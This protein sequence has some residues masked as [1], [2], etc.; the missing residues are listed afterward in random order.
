MGLIIYYACNTL[1]VWFTN[2]TSKFLSDFVNEHTNSQQLL[3]GPVLVAQY[4]E[5]AQPFSCKSPPSPSHVCES[6]S[7]NLQ[8]TLHSLGYYYNF[9]IYCM[10]ITLVRPTPQRGIGG[11]SGFILGCRAV[12][13]KKSLQKKI[14]GTSGSFGLW[15]FRSTANCRELVATQ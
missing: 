7:W 2:L 1:E 3:S 6:F 9:F 5:Q 4:G 11:Y 14:A 13:A 8:Q 10:C 12:E 15:K